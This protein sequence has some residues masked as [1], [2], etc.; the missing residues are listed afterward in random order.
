MGSSSSCTLD[1]LSD[2]GCQKAVRVAA[3]WRI[4]A[5]F[6]LRLA[7]RWMAPS[8]WWASQEAAELRPKMAAETELRR[9]LRGS[10]HGRRN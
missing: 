8:E 1:G 10:R 6:I 7:R 4:C 5:K 3:P 9:L 2:K